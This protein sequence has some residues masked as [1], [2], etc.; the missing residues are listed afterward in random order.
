MVQKVGNIVR[1]DVLI[2]LPK[3]IRASHKL[4][5][6]AVNTFAAEDR[7]EKYACRT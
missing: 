4:S 5:R 6:G 1:V 3:E 7:R 2:R